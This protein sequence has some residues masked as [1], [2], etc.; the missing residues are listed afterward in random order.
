MYKLKTPQAPL[1]LTT[2]GMI[3]FVAAAG[4]MWVE[5]D[6]VGLLNTA[7]LWMIVYGAVI[8]SFLG[9][10][11]WGVEMARRDKPRFGELGLAI[12]GALVGWG[13][14]LAFFRWNHAAV[15]PGMAAALLF[16]FG[17]D[18]MSGEMP[19][20]YRKLRVWPT[21]AAVLSLVAAYFL[22]RGI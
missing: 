15:F 12:L 9:G 17:I 3:P 21:G 19:M 14:V 10:V 22:L 8:L 16:Y 4:V 2:A 11:R 5:R 13:L 18:R 1:A 6:N 20:W 7:A